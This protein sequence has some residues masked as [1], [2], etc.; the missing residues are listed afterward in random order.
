MNCTTTTHW[1]THIS[2]ECSAGGSA[3]CDGFCENHGDECTC[4]CHKDYT[5]NLPNTVEG[6]RHWH[7]EYNDLHGSFED[8]TVG[9]QWTNAGLACD[10]L[11]NKPVDGSLY[12]VRQG[13]DRVVIVR[14]WR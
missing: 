12:V 5:T 14:Q 1:E 13:Q 9:E 11:N 7:D 4:A 6:M 2:A 8:G 3:Q 10:R